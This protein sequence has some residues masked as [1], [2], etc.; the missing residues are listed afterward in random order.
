MAVKE[1]TQKDVYNY[2]AKN[3]K[4]ASHYPMICFEKGV[5]DSIDESK[6]LNDPL[7]DGKTIRENGVEPCRWL[8][9]MI[10]TTIV[11]IA[12]FSIVQDYDAE[13][14]K[15]IPDT[16][17]LHIDL[18]ETSSKMQDKGYAKLMLLEIKNRASS[19]KCVKK[20]R[21]IPYDVESREFW[22]EI[23]AKPVYN[24]KKEII[25]YELTF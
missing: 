13:T 23:G 19:L 10:S 7:Y 4:I 14:E 15:Y 11:N 16:R 25:F 8:Q 6:F 5:V 3:K 9:Y 24:S 1:V 18:I 2:F 20:L 22:K 17:V 12:A 21:I